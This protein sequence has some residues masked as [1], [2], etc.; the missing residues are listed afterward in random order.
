MAKILIV[1][2]DAHIR[3]LIHAILKAEKERNRYIDII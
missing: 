3:E 1:N 2:N